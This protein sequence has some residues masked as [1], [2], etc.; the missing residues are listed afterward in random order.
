M[1]LALRGGRLVA[2]AAWRG[3]PESHTPALLDFLDLGDAPDRV[4]VGAR[5]LS[6]ALGEVVAPGDPPPDYVRFVAP[7]WRED[8]DVRGEV[9]DVMEVVRRTGGEL[10]AE[11][12]RFEWRP[13]TP[14][15]A[16]DPRLRFRPLRD[17]EELLELMTA[18]LTGTRDAYSRLDLARMSARETAA[19]HVR[20]ELTSYATPREWWQVATLP[21]GDPV[22]FVIPAHNRY[23]PIIA[24]IA[25]LPEHRGRGHV[26]AILAH[27]V[28]TLAAHDAPRIRASTDLGNEAMARAF[29]RAGWRNFERS[30]NMSW[31]PERG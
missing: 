25:V 12:F 29:V 24:Y 20:T 7:D 14:I 22:G 27:G 6:R 31:Q 5:L 1:W 9:D 4:D 8:R 13:E 23:G 10:V 15:A 11:R 26:D 21:G 18:A 28:R 17:E 3:D 19:R 16:P 30:I 2:R